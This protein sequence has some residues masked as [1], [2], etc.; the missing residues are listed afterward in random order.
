MSCQDNQL[1]FLE[2]DLF[3]D[4]LNLSHLFLHGN[5]LWSLRQNTFR[6]LGVLDRLLL[7]QNRIQWVDR[8][9]FHDLR[10]L[11]TLYLFNNSLT[12]LSGASLT[13]LPAL[14]Y[15]RLNDNPWECDCKALSLWDWLRRFRGSTS[16]LMCVSPPELAG[17]DLKTLKKE[18]LPSCLSGE[19]HARGTPG[20][21]TEHGESL[22]HLNRHRNHHNHHQRPYLP[23]GDQYSL[24]SPSPLPRPP[25]SRKNCT[26]QGRKAKGEL[27]EVQVLRE[28]GKKDYTPDGE[29]Y[30]LSVT[31]RR[32]HKCNP[33][34][35]VGPPSGVQRANNKAGS[36]LANYIFCF[37]SAL[38]LSL[39]SAIP[40]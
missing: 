27:N 13:L 30:D 25:R 15:L 28:G 39:I 5:R 18:E 11:T 7:H 1:E 23:H 40:R 29:K 22:N 14:E 2:D 16:S 20:R 12:E 24:P 32:K 37:S 33:R 35:S 36:H 4:L 3:I 31:G 9:A 38:L 6:G 17:K 21:E 10:R 8:Q 34:T 26:R 19:G